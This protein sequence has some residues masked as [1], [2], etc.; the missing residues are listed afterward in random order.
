VNPSGT[1]EEIKKIWQSVYPNNI[2][3]YHFLD[4]QIA[5]FYQK[6]DLLNK[7]IGSFAI[8]AIVISC[9]GLL[10]LIS[11]MTIQRTKEIGIRKVI[12]ASVASITILLSKDFAKLVFL[13]LILATALAWF[14]MNKWLQ[15]FAYRISIPW[16]IFFLAGI[17]NLTLAFI[18]ISFHAVKAATTNPTKSLRAE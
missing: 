11:L 5:E 10:G 16:W 2:F 15:G 13:A 12:G 8:L 6:E 9:V 1:I 4:E 17:S 18:T 3:E 14:I 7:L